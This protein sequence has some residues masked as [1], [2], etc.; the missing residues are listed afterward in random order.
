[1]TLAAIDR[2][3]YHATNERRELSQTRCARMKTLSGTAAL[4]RGTENRR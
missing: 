4:A 2:L 3:V 1:M